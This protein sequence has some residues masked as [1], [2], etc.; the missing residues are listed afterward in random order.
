MQ[1]GKLKTDLENAIAGLEQ[2]RETHMG[3]DYYNFPT[4]R[5]AEFLDVELFHT[6]PLEDWQDL[7]GDGTVDNPGL[8]SNFLLEQDTISPGELARR[9]AAESQILRGQE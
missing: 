6:I 5:V 1:D 9:L 2:A 4:I 3:N 7:R 8:I